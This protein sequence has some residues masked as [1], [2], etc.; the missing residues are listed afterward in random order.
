MVEEYQ[1]VEN[2]LSLGELPYAAALLFHARPQRFLPMAQT[3]CARFDGTA[4]VRFLDEQ[5]FDG[6]VIFQ[7]E[8]A[9]AFV[10]R[11]TRRELRITGAAAHEV[12][13]EYPDEAVREAIT[14]AVCHRDYTVHATVQ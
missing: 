14:N 3:Q 6:D 11:N 1:N 7:I 9:I 8:S 4:S 13:P 10:R 5:T 2:K 12:I